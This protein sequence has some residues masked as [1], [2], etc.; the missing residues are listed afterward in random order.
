MDRSVGIRLQGCC[1]YNAKDKSYRKQLLDKCT[2]L[3]CCEA[4][5]GEKTTFYVEKMLKEKNLE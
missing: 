4:E 1:F 3:S 5:T 2:L